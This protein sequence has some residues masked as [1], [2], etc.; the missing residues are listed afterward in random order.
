[1]SPFQSIAAL[2]V[3]SALLVGC[4]PVAVVSGVASISSLT[5]TKKTIA[6]HVATGIMGRDCSSVTFEQTGHYCPEQVVADQSKLYCFRTLA[7]VDCHY[8]P[9]PY[10]N[11]SVALASP[12]PALIPVKDKPGWFDP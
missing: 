11:G 10:K 3:I 8:L 4:G 1:M 7:D 12:P 5:A 6:D 9:D 2:T